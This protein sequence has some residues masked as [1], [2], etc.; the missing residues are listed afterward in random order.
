MSAK[1][2]TGSLLTEKVAVINRW[3]WYFKSLL[4]VDDGRGARIDWGKDEWE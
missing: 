1:D 3:N 4:N 2:D